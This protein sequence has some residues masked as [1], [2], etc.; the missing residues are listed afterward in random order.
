[1]EV[2]VR[3]AVAAARASCL[4]VHDDVSLDLVVR[5]ADFPSRQ[6]VCVSGSSFGPGRI[7]VIIDPS[8][9][10][11]LSELHDAIVRCVF[12]EFH[13]ILRWDGPGYGSTLGAALVSEGLAQHFVHEMM[14]CGPEP[15][16]RILN[17]PDLYNLEKAAASGFDDD[18]YD[19]FEWFYGGGKLPCW[20]GYSVGFAMIERFLS[21]HPDVS[22]LSCATQPADVFRD[23]LQHRT[24]D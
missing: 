8:C 7:E 3:D 18:R 13:H 4:A 20:A 15:W 24:G 6:G 5:V 17:E 12:H 1:M 10:L 11:P 23:Y 22:V 16:E 9:L 21:K 19:H 2:A 14:D